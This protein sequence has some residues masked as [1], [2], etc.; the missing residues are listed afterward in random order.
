MILKDYLARIGLE[1]ETRADLAT[2]ARVHRRH[3][4]A[5]PYENLD[6]QF[7]RPV[8]RETSAIYEKIVKRRRGGWCYEMNGLLAWALEAIGFRV[9]RLA[10]A[11]MR[12]TVGDDVIGNHLVL[13]VDLGETYVCDAGFGDGLIE[14]VPLKEGPFS[15]GPLVCSIETVEGGWRRY[16]NDPKGSAPSFDFHPEMRDERLLER[17]CRW[18]QG[19]PSSPFVQNAVVQRWRNDEHYSLRGRILTIT[20][21][22]GKET[23]LIKD[24]GAYVATLRAV[25]A[26]DLPEAASL[27]PKICA[28]HDI[29]MQGAAAPALTLR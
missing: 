27:W 2:L 21:A 13:L 20:S 19:D 24:A 26:L 7:G 14:P 16:R 22:R 25:F 5:I 4:E 3:V 1:G 28:R 8:T 23:R 11:V 9:T 6:V 29:V 18:L 10:G 17:Q 12:E 15:V